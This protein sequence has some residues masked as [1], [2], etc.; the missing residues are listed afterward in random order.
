MYDKELILSKLKNIKTSLE[1]I[2]DWTGHVQSEDDFLTS[3]SGM[4]LLNAVCMKL[5]WI[6]EEVK[7]IDKHT[8]KKLFS[9]YPDV[10]WKELMGMRDIIAHR[11]FELETDKIF[12]A[13]DKDVP[14]ILETVSKIINEYR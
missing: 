2:I 5:L 13:I 9:L 3:S 14:N 7:S 4:I 1:E 8:D 11:Y 12:E 6:G 10:H